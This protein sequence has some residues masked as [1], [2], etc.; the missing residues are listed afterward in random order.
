MKIA[1]V[2]PTYFD[3]QSVMAGGERYAYGLAQAVAQKA[4]T[5]LFTFSDRRRTLQDGKLTIQYHKTLFPVGGIQNPFC[6]SFLND[7]KNFD[8]IHCLQFKTI[9]TDFAMIAGFCRG[10]KVFIT[11][12][13]GGTY[14]CPSHYVPLWKKTRGF[15]YISDFNRGLNQKI[16]R[17]YRI[18]YGGVDIDSFAPPRES[19]NRRRFLYVGRIFF[20]KGLHH[21]VDAVAPG[22]QLDIIGNSYEPD[23][24]ASLKQKSQGKDIAFLEGVQDHALVGKF[25]SAIATVL[26]SLADGGFTSAIESLA[27]GTPVIGT[28]LGSLPEVVEDGVTGFLVPPNDSA[29]LRDRMNF[30]VKNPDKAREMGKKARQSAVTKFTWNKVADCCLDAY[31]NL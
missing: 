16:D 2:M 4:E 23:Y 31:Q 24:S 26:P 1:F 19:Q 5:S 27:C 6:L 28:R 3:P 20:L 12:L 9:V 14:Y 18:L 29:A 25:Q 15:L 8:L 7:L 13:A 22:I 30:L 17:P 10:K 11:D 21:L